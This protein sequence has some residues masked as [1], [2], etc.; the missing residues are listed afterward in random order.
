[1]DPGENRYCGTTC[2]SWRNGYDT[3][4]RSGPQSIGTGRKNCRRNRSDSGS[5]LFS[6]AVSALLRLPGTGSHRCGE[7]IGFRREC[8]L[9]RI[10]ICP[11]YC[12]CLSA[13][14]TCGKCAGH[15]QRSVVQAGGLDGSE[16]L[17]P[18][19]RRCR[20]GSRREVQGRVP[21]GGIR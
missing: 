11:E 3:C 16:Q 7:C 17:Y 4:V 10:F 9:L 18:V 13:D 12:G 2:V 21:S 14:G 15:R 6:G 8:G 1:M 20:G 19:R 5:K